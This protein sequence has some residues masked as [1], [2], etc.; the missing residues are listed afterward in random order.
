MSNDDSV[1]FEH[2]AAGAI[3]MDDWYWY[4]IVWGPLK[5]ERILFDDAA[6]RQ[7]Y[8]GPSQGAKTYFT[9]MGFE[10]PDSE[11]PGSVWG[12]TSVWISSFVE[13]WINGTSPILSHFQQA[14]HLKLRDFPS[15][16][17]ITG[18]CPKNLPR[19]RFRGLWRDLRNRPLDCRRNAFRKKYP[20]T[21]DDCAQRA[22]TTAGPRANLVLLQVCILNLTHA[23]GHVYLKLPKMFC[24]SL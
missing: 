23:C 16:G 17:G 20:L 19:I 8:L 24:F 3:Q 2:L 11:S 22:L 1:R 4:G 7:V 15:P 13:S 14:N 18:G 10:M 5:S 12:W 21:V 9:S 6:M